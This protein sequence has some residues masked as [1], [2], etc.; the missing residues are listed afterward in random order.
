MVLVLAAIYGGFV[1]LV[2]YKFKLMEF[3][4]T[5]K[6]IVIAVGVISIMALLFT[7]QRTSP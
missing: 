1:W 4:R 6:I 5:R 2:F 7:I 3:T